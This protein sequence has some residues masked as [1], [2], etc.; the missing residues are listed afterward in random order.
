MSVLADPRAAAWD[1][2][3]RDPCAADLAYPCYAG[4]DN[5]YLIR[6]V[7]YFNP[8]APGA[9]LVVDVTGTVDGYIQIVPHNLSSTTGYV[10]AF[11]TG[12]GGIGNAAASGE[13][14]NFVCNTNVVGRYRPVAAC[15]KWIPTGPYGNRSGTVGLAYNPGAV[16]TAGESS[17]NTDQLLA[18]CQ[19]QSPNGSTAHE[20]RWLPTNVDENFV[21]V[22]A[23]NNGAGAMFIVLRGVDGINTSTTTRNANGL[24]QITTIY[25]WTPA[26]LLGV[27]TAPRAPLPYTSQQVLS[28]I[29]DLGAYLFS[30]IRAAARVAGVVQNA[31]NTYN[32]LLTSGMRVI[33]TRGGGMPQLQY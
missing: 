24:V 1:R 9:G 19:H 25:E 32:S 13:G 20:V 30:G 5:G 15:A 22:N 14:G 11:A 31:S 21:S 4:T 23:N 28:S 27:S 26:R 29:S 3:L 10:S 18:L 33:Q 2:L 8:V 16:I 7:D 12:G 6:T 17:A